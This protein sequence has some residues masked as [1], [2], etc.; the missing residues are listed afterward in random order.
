MKATLLVYKANE[1][2]QF[3]RINEKN[4]KMNQIVFEEQCLPEKYLS[5]SDLRWTALFSYQCTDIY[6]T[7]MLGPEIQ[8][9]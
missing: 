7:D 6:D 4:R 9:I 1:K 2:K 3:W 8:L 5:F